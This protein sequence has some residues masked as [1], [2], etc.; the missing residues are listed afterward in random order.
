MQYAVTVVPAFVLLDAA[1][2]IVDR[3][4][5]GDDV[6]RLTQAVSALSSRGAPAAA[7]ATAS[8]ASAPPATTPAPD[9]SISQEDALNARLKSLIN[10]SQVMLFMKGVPTAP[11]CGF[12][13]Q[14]VECLA[15]AKISF[16]TFDIL[17][18]EDVRQG[19]KQ[20]SDW[21]TYPQL[22]ANGE[23]IGGLDIMKEMSEE[24]DLAEQLGV[25]KSG[26]VIGGGAGAEESLDDRLKKLVNRHRV[27]LFMKGLPS[28]PRCGF[29]RQIVEMLDEEGASYDSFNILEDEEVRQG[30]K[31]YSDWPTYPQLYVDGDLVG[32]LDIVKELKEGGDLTDLVKG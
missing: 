24:G 4:D 13:R 11:R 20:Y 15:D 32:G 1:G 6:P 26:A 19:L 17:T 22:Y 21:P 30:L 10:S 28:A 7:A 27:M 23:L 18:D 5:G 12:S 16:G 14:A 25:A 2:T 8:S 29:S 3:V 9:A 31:K